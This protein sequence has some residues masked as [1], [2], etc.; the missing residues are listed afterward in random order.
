M[1]LKRIRRKKEG[2]KNRDELGTLQILLHSWSGKISV[3]LLLAMIILALGTIA[4]YKP[5][6]FKDY[7]KKKQLFPYLYPEKAPPCWSVDKA[8]GLYV[9]QDQMKRMLTAVNSTSQISNASITP[10]YKRLVDA[11]LKRFDAVI[12]NETYEYKFN[13]ETENNAWPSD[14][15]LVIIYKFDNNTVLKIGNNKVTLVFL[16]IYLERP[17]GIRIY[18]Y[19]GKYQPSLGNITSLIGD[20]KRNVSFLGKT[21]PIF[22]MPTSVNSL[23]GSK[24]GS[25]SPIA[26]KLADEMQK[27]ADQLFGNNTE[28]KKK[29]FVANYGRALY[30][31]PDETGTKLVVASG[32]YKIHFEIDYVVSR[33]LV[34]NSEGKYD[35]AIAK[36]NDASVDVIGL[37]YAIRPNC[38]GFF[39]TDTN[40]RPVGLGLL[41][42]LPYAFLLGFIVTFTSTFIG[43]FYGS[44]A[45]YW[46]DLK[47]EAMMRVVD[48]VNS[49]P[50]LPILIA[51][52][53]AIKT[54]NIWMLA[55]LMIALFWAGPVIVVRSMA[56]QISEQIYVEAARAIGAS[57]KRILF[58]HV[59]PQVFPYTMA[60]AVLSMPGVII[61]EASLALLGFGDPSAPT[62]GKLLQAAYNAHAVQNGFWWLYIFPGLA[63]VIFSATFLILGRALEPLVAPKLIK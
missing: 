28:L 62:W 57:T 17:D 61:A 5:S 59:F 19:T 10:K 13:Y 15:G 31:K 6:G 22:Y 46:K 45:G 32:E 43:A 55:A 29:F 23:N 8:P 40:S 9:T 53:V 14:T 18:F 20:M 47:G 50:F 63:L 12:V 51:L 24:V 54:I 48:V 39:G 36:K 27:V 49:L 58:R 1:V 52:S 41:F 21:Y 16:N 42:G 11:V 7:E 30:L 25:S 60:I 37:V 2:K 56:L 38:Y 3:A 26:S 44:A 35:P 33:D 34:T 4:Y